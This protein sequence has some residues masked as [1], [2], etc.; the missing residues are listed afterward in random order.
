[1]LH[2]QGIA[3]IEAAQ[4][5]GAVLAKRAAEPAPAADENA[6][7]ADGHGNNDGQE[8]IEHVDLPNQQLACARQ[9]DGQ[10]G[11]VV[12]INLACRRRQHRPHA[13]KPLADHLRRFADRLA[14]TGHAVMEA[15]HAGFREIGTR[16]ARQIAHGIDR[17]VQQEFAQARP[18][19][20][21]TQPQRTQQVADVIAHVAPLRRPGNLQQ[22]AQPVNPFRDEPA[23]GPRPHVGASQDHVQIPAKENAGPFHITGPVAQELHVFPVMAFL[24]RLQVMPV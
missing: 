24:Q 9:L 13:A 19:H 14:A 3:R 16:A 8:Q 2:R 5:P 12:G 17:T 22:Q 15:Q 1:M 6:A 18:A 7:H 4:A 23:P 21:F 10:R 20:D 11:V